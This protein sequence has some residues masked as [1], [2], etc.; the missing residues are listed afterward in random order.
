MGT[1]DYLAPEQA[2]NSHGVDSRADIYS[3]GC[4]LYFLLVGHP[5]FPKG[6]L[7][8]RIANHQSVDPP[9]LTTLREDVPET[10]LGII[11][12]MMTKDPDERMQTC[13]DVQASLEHFLASEEI[14]DTVTLIKPEPES[15]SDGPSKKLKTDANDERPASG[16]T[17]KSSQLGTIE[18]DTGP[19]KRST[20]AKA[21][22]KV[23]SKV[24][25]SKS[26]FTK[27]T[28]TPAWVLPAIIG[29]MFLALAAVFWIVVRLTQ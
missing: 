11:D 24:A 23:Q 9:S 25:T 22:A 13:D 4:T 21:S 3:L 28:E 8:Q 2:I 16:S 27:K 14:P 20:K 12:A 5:P 18:I 6:S 1:A 10:L 29:G 19:R 17:N 26:R 7:A 15:E